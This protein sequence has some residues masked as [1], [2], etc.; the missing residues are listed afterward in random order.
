[1]NDARYPVRYR[2]AASIA[3]FGAVALPVLH[4]TQPTP[5]PSPPAPVS[6]A[7]SR[8]PVASGGG[9]LYG[10]NC[11]S[12]HGQ[13]GEGTPRG[14]SLLGVGSASVDFQL[15]TGRMPLSNG[16][17]YRPRHR[18]PR[19]SPADID[20]LVGYVAA[21]G[22]GTG[23]A[24]PTIR[25]GDVHNGRTLYATHCAACHS[26][27]GTGAALSNGQTAPSLLRAT[28]TQV[29]EAIR[30]GPGLMPAFSDTLLDTNDVNAIAGYVQVLQNRPA[31]TDRGGL[32]LGR[33]GPFT[34]GVVAWVL[35][36]ATLVFAAWWLGSRAR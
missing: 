30:V 19:L 17:Q 1:M 34:E 21:L 28:P 31:D 20:A 22:N 8:P 36:L 35:G 7:P 3:V 6:P 14:P 10:Q 16:E 18:D 33:V 27:T 5:P 23:P 11:A 13:R 25:A 29:G 2:L 4:P 15:G 12:C 26:A 24:I 32:P 9:E